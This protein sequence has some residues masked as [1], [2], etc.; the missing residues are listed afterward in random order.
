MKNF[1]KKI[2][3]DPYVDW[4]LIVLVGVCG[5]I[6][7]TLWS[8]VVYRS[9]TTIDQTSTSASSTQIMLVDVKKVESVIK[10]FEERAPSMIDVRDPSL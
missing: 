4:L 8:I 6:A 10:Y 2:T 1:F 7:V 5:V 9:T 3:H